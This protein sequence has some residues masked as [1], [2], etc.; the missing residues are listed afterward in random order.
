LII[1]IVSEEQVSSF[2]IKIK[3]IKESKEEV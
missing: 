3:E 1:S 2:E